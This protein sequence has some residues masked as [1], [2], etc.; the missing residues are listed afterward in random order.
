MGNDLFPDSLSTNSPNRLSS[1]SR[2]EPTDTPSTTSD[3]PVSTRPNKSSPVL[4]PTKHSSFINFIPYFLLQQSPP[5]LVNQM[6][7]PGY[8]VHS[9]ALLIHTVCS[10]GRRLSVFRDLEIFVIN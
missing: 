9:E 5:P 8:F 10:N 7:C 2:E 4:H 6:L 3:L 1:V